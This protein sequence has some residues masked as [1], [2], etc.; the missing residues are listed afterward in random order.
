MS[1]EHYNR[2]FRMVQKGLPVTLSMEL[3]AAYTNPDEMEH[4]IIAEIPGTDLKDEVVM[5][6]AHFDS[7]HSGT[8]ATDNA[9]GSSVMMEAARI[10]LQVIKE[11]GVQ[12]AAPC[13]WLCGR[14][15]S[16]DCWAPEGMSATIL[17]LR[18]RM[19]AS[20]NLNRSRPKYRPI[21]TWITVPGK[22]AG[23]T[24]RAIRR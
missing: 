9:A 10:L 20:R 15:K 7:W 13:A 18:P 1:V 6:G 23:F 11:T 22:S 8:G 16:R 21:T 3:K 2:I 14:A 12:P 17:R 19:A 5:F 24:F 4:N